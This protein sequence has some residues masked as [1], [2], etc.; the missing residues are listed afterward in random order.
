M[1][2]KRAFVLFFDGGVSPLIERAVQK[3]FLLHLVSLKRYDRVQL[4]F[5]IVIDFVFSAY[6]KWIL[7]RIITL[8]VE[9]FERIQIELA[10]DNW[11][12]SGLNFRNPGN[13]LNVLQEIQ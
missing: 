4:L 2:W 11:N 8:E 9:G 10:W 13:Y 1:G 7:V 6:S 12:I 5:V 3:V